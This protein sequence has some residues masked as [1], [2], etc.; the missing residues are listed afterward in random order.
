VA[1]G[2]DLSARKSL[3]DSIGNSVKESIKIP[4][5]QYEWGKEYTKP[6]VTDY[7]AAV[8]YDAV[9][10]DLSGNPIHDT[11]SY[12]RHEESGKTTWNYSG[13]NWLLLST[14]DTKQQDETIGLLFKLQSD[15]VNLP[16]ANKAKVSYF[17]AIEKTRQL[18]TMVTITTN[19][20]RGKRCDYCKK[21]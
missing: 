18:N 1:M 8:I 17:E 11:K 10:C 20:P 5:V 16:E 4:L 21:L 19:L 3:F 9:F 15:L 12:L 7:Y 2:K 14:D 6:Y 13:W